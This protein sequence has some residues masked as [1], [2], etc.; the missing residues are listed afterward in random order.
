MKAFG[1]ALLALVVS[2]QVHALAVTCVGTG[3]FSNVSSA[4][5]RLPTNTPT[6][7]LKLKD[8]GSLSVLL[9]ATNRDGSSYIEIKA[10]NI[11]TSKGL[12]KVGGAKGSSKDVVVYLDDQSTLSCMP[13]NQ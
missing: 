3:A 13:I 5:I 10:I 12:V 11:D 2:N 7:I 8:G 6:D 4:A 1:L 9:D